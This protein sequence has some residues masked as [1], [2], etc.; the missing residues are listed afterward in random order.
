MRSIN[1]EKKAVVWLGLA[2]VTLVVLALPRIEVLSA[3]TRNWRAMLLAVLFAPFLWIIRHLSIWLKERQSWD[4]ISAWSGEQFALEQE[5]RLQR[6]QIIVALGALY[7]LILAA[8]W[9]FSNAV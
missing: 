2:G 5:R 3:L 6:S 9:I 7:F 1:S 4:E 8:G